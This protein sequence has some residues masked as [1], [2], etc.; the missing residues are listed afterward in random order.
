MEPIDLIAVAAVLHVLRQGA[1]LESDP[2]PP[3]P[4]PPLL[5]LLLPLI[6]LQ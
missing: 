2:V 4:S 5:R 3:P 1:A 6:D